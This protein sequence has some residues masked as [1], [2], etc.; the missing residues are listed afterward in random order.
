MT[1]DITALS[2]RDIVRKVQSSELTAEAVTRAFL[3][4]VLEKE[5][6]LKA[7][8][9]LDAQAPIHE[10]SALTLARLAGPLAGIP[11]DVCPMGG[12]DNATLNGSDAIGLKSE[13]LTH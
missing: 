4:R 6:V 12:G 5:P 13:A 11:I 10:A 9:H 8:A 3:E 2:A 7:F 1:L